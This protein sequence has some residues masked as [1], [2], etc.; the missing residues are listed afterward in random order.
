M[1][2]GFDSWTR[3]L[4]PLGIGKSHFLKGKSSFLP[5]RIYKNMQFSIAMLNNQT[6]G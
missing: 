5:S 3:N 6:L 2:T 1:L 4:M